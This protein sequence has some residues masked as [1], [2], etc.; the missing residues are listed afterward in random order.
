MV[1]LM[2][3][4][5]AASIRLSEDERARLAPELI[6]V[7][8]G[9]GDGDGRL[10]GRSRPDGEREYD[11]I[12]RSAAPDEVVALGITPRSRFGGIL[13]AFV[14]ARELVLLARSEFVEYVEPGSINYPQ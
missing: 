9:R 2:L 6:A 3:M 12:I 11:V 10:A 5:C 8:E 13:T 4:H 14:T 1:A 7:A